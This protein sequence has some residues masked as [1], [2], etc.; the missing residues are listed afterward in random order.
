MLD[1]PQKTAGSAVPQGMASRFDF[2]AD[3]Q[4]LTLFCKLSKPATAAAFHR[5]HLLLAG[6]VRDVHVDP[7]MRVKGVHFS[8]DTLK[9]LCFRGVVPVGMVRPCRQCK[10]NHS[11]DGDRNNNSLFKTHAKSPL[12]YWN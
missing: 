7:G 8:D 12:I 4:T 1:K 6:L 10:C 2:V 9:I 3:L 11:D 5:P